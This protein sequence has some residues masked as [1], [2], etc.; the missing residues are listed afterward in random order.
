M[1]I[2]TELKNRLICPSDKTNLILQNESMISTGEPPQK[3]PVVNGVP[4]LINQQ[5]SLFKIDDFVSNNQTTY[6]F[7]KSKKEE[8][9]KR[10]IPAIGVNIK[11]EENYKWINNHLPDSA[12]ILVVGGGIQGNG[13]SILYDNLKANYEI[14]GSDVSFESYT[15]LISDAHDIPFED[16]SFDCVIAQAV[17][18]HVLSPE[19]CVN[20]IHRVLKPSG[21]VY[22]ET[23]F[24]QQV[25]MKQYDFTRFTHLGHRWL[26]RKFTKIYDGTCSGPGMALA[27]SYRYFLM[28]FATTY[29]TRKLLSAFARFTSFYLK[30]FDKFLIDSAGAFDAASGYYFLGRKSTT[31]LSKEDLI[32]EFKGAE[33]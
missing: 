11:A 3:Y 24:M 21:I 17:L 7:N 27:W 2:S 6:S 13:I 18:E 32:N 29:R 1:K 22:A 25:H 19:R 9:F 28:S 26:I 12:K 30:Y 4:V 20:E 33:F 16:E 10:I 23:P 5:N 8:V 14:V 31:T 15:D